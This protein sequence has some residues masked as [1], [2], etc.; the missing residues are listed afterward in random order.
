MKNLKS[1]LVVSCVI[2]LFVFQ[3]AFSQTYSEKDTSNKEAV[4]EQRLTPTVL[5]NLGFSTAP[6]PRSAIIQN[7][8][9]FIRQIGDYNQAAIATNTEASEINLLQNGNYNNTT[10]DYTSKTAI[11]NLLQNGDSNRIFD[12][13]NNPEADVS[14]DLIQNGNNLN[15]ERNGVNEITKSLRFRQT[16]ASPSIIIRSF[17]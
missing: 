3:F 6:N 17:N 14:L 8:A 5:A 10:L 11:A 2:T 16:E 15:F 4:T 13:A 1:K 9:D 12:F 7:N